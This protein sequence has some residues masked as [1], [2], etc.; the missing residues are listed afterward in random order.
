M[1]TT[2][3][4]CSTSILRDNSVQS[5]LN[6][7]GKSNLCALTGFQKIENAIFT[8]NHCIYFTPIFG[9]SIFQWTAWNLFSTIFANNDIKKE[10]HSQFRESYYCQMLVTDCSEEGCLVMQILE[11]IQ[12]TK[13]GS[14]ILI[15]Y[16]AEFSQEYCQPLSKV[17]QMNSMLTNMRIH[18]H[19]VWWWVLNHLNLNASLTWRLLGQTRNS[20]LGGPIIS[21]W[22]N[23]SGC[24]D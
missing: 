21:T 16:Y 20:S 6:L 14:H 11:N 15:A 17:N 8:G 18:Y 24:M 19:V 4:D 22:C 10:L 2:S 3:T 13:H 7:A 12:L 9:I 23:V 1:Q 5:Q